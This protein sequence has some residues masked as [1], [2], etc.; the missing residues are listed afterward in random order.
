MRC[1]IRYFRSQGH[2][3][4][5]FLDDGLGGHTYKDKALHL[6]S[7]VHNTL[8]KFFFFFLISEKCDWDPKQHAT[9]LG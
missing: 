6:S 7:H 1:L 5:M 8:I 4:V 3:V 9:W 2:K